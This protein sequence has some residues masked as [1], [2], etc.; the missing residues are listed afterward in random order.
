MNI[1]HGLCPHTKDSPQSS[2]E[3]AKQGRQVLEPHTILVPN[4]FLALGIGWRC[5]LHS[6]QHAPS[7]LPIGLSLSSFLCTWLSIS[8]LSEL[9]INAK[10]WPFP[11]DNFLFTTAGRPNQAVNFCEDY[12]TSWVADT[13]WPLAASHAMYSRTALHFR[14][15]CLHITAGQ[16][17]APNTGTNS[18]VLKGDIFLSTGI[19]VPWL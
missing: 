3:K 7:L 12:C 14:G 19:R 15:Y 2:P 4:Q 18:N 1:R 10:V 6:W 8:T 17:N 5:T 11:P 16:M 13:T 9:S